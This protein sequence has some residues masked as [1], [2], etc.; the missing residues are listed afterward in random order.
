MFAVRSVVVA[1]DCD[2]WGRFGAGKLGSFDAY[3]VDP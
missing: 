3:L 1:V 2:K